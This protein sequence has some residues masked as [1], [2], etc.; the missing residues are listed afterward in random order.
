LGTTP[1]KPAASIVHF[2]SCL[3]RPRRGLDEVWVAEVYETK[4]GVDAFFY[5]FRGDRELI[6]ATN[7]EGFM[8]GADYDNCWQR[9]IDDEDAKK[10]RGEELS[11][12]P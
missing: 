1:K 8:F 2:R 6:E 12:V 3:A 5:A 4:V 10:A 11:S 7:P 9:V